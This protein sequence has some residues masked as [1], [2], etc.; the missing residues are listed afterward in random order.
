M[1][2]ILAVLAILL[3]ISLLATP[4]STRQARAHV[5]ERATVCGTVKGGRYLPSLR[6]E[7][8]FLNLDGHYPHQAFTVVIW[9][10]HRPQFDRPEQRLL[11]KRICVSGTIGAYRGVPQIVVRTPSQITLAK[12]VHDG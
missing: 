1:K 9:G 8:T 3:G 12:E 11:G 4:I 10:E 7:P 6:G 5:G 2:R